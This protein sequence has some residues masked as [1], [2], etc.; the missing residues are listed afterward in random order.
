MMIELPGVEI[1]SETPIERVQSNEI[2]GH[3][4]DTRSLQGKNAFTYRRK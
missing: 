4:N 1:A 3:A 2:S